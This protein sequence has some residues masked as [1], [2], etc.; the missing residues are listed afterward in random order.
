[1]FLSD[2]V[3][4]IF[5][6]VSSTGPEYPYISNY[7]LIFDAITCKQLYSEL[8]KSITSN[9]FY[10]Q[11]EKNKY[12]AMARGRCPGLWS[13]YEFFS[14]LDE[15]NEKNKGEWKQF[16]K[17]EDAIDFL[18]KNFVPGKDKFPDILA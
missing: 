2:Y 10:I 14:T 18:Y 3:T 8:E 9:T 16:S 6:S 4:V 15:D 1:M 13:Y 17:K 7:T 11:M 5:P 12:I